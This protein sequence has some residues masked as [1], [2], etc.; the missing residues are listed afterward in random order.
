M[1]PSYILTDGRVWMMS[2]DSDRHEKKREK[3]S[4]KLKKDYVEKVKN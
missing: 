1:D 4:K 2:Q 3:E